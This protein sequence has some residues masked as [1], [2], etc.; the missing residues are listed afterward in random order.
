[1]SISSCGLSGIVAKVRP[2]SSNLHEMLIEMFRFRPS[3]AADLLAGVLGLNVPAHQ[4]VRLE[5]VDCTNLVPTEY[6]AD[7]VCEAE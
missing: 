6:R 5:P 2:V 4:Q 1:M 3:L 7:A